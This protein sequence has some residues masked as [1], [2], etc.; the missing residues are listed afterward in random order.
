MEA[1][2]AEISRLTAAQR[3]AAERAEQASGAFT[4][5]ET[6]VAG[7][8]AGEFGLD[9]D[10]E[11]AVKILDEIEKQQADLRRHEQV[12]THERAALAARVEGLRVGLTRKDATAALLA[13]TDQLDG[14]LGSVAALIKVQSPYETAIAAAFGAAADAVAVTDLDAAMDTFDHL[15]AEDLGRA[16]LLLGGVVETE[17]TAEWPALPGGARYAVGLVEV[18]DQL[19]AAV[20]RALRKVAVVENLSAAQ[21]LISHLPDVVAVTHDG[22]VVSA[23]FAA[24]GSSATPTLIEVQAAIDDAERR[25][26][27]TSHACD[28]LRFAQSQLEEQHRQASAI[29]EDTLARLHESDAAMAALAEEL[30]QLS[31]TARSRTRS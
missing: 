10:H 20:Q 13:A 8:D 3:Q 9:A 14:L 6:K 30:G 23:H 26:T 21:S 25:L 15:K 27:E 31:S 5:L 24:G 11:S 7:L 4:A 18:P 28:R 19:T 16:G 1:A 22:D 17:R 2:A 12:A 29:V